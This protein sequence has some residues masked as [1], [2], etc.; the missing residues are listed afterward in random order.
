ME[1]LKQ[2][3]KETIAAIAEQ[4]TRQVMENRQGRLKQCLRNGGRHLSDILYKT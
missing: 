1:E 3:M 2:R 4:M